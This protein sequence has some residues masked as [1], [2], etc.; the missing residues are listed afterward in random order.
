MSE[1]GMSGLRSAAAAKKAFA[2]GGYDDVEFK[3]KDGD[4][5]II[6]VLDPAS[7]IDKQWSFVHEMPPTGKMKWGENVPCLGGQAPDAHPGCPACQRGIEK[8]IEGAVNVIWRNGPQYASKLIEGKTV[9]DWKNITGKADCLA[10]WT[11]GITRLEE[12]DSLDSAY[13]GIMTRDFQVKRKGTGFDT[14]YSFAPAMDSD[15]N[16]MATPPSEADLKLAEKKPDLAARA[17]PGTAEEMERRLTG[18]AGGS[19][20][21]MATSDDDI[22]QAF[23]ASS[24]TSPFAKN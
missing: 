3:V 5:E 14:V 21:S 11:M 6:R 1:G 18:A 2:G 8:S 13:K 4:T 10:V 15:G 7:Q 16:A 24:D 19:N 12:L 17:R 20:N 9:R 22:A 23:A